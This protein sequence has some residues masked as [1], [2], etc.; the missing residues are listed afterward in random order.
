MENT[1][2]INGLCN[3]PLN[4]ANKTKELNTIITL[5]EYKKHKKQ[6]YQHIENKKPKESH[7]IKMIN[8]LCLHT[9]VTT[10]TIIKVFKN[11]GVKLPLKK[12]I[13]SNTYSI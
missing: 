10:H 12:S 9:Q 5:A 8:R 13:Q 1:N 2:L 11:T 6:P 7:K 4:E 3:L